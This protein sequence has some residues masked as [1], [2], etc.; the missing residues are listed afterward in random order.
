MFIDFEGMDPAD[1][2]QVMTQAV[3]PRPVAWVLSENPAGDYNLAPFSFFTPITSHPP[4][5][6]FSVGRKPTD[7]A[8]KD[9]RVNI[10]ARKDFVVHIAHRDLAKAMTATSR[11]LPHGE[12]ELAELGLELTP[13]EGSRL[14]RLKDCHVAL[15]CE[16]SEIKELGAVPQSLVFGLVKGVF[17]ADPATY[18]DEKGRLRIDGA[19]VDPIGRLG[20]SEYVTFG[21]VLKVPR[22]S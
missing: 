7:N 10:E 2:Y 19:A 12:S 13:F 1:I 6:M 9:T 4:L 20:G 11:T 8:F 22:P 16:L 21:E 5:I 14:P 17:V 15:A 18:Q 3:I